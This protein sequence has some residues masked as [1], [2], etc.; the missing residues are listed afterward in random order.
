VKWRRLLRW[1]ASRLGLLCVALVL[2]LLVGELILRVAGTPTEQPQQQHRQAAD[3]RFLACDHD[4]LLGWIFPANAAGDFEDDR[5][6]II[7]HTNSWGLRG[8][9]I[10][11]DP[12][13]AHI[14]VLGDSYTF[15][16]G[17]EEAEGFPRRLEHRLRQQYPELSLTVVNT[18]I[19]GYGPYQQNRMLEYVCRRLRPDVV[20]ATFSLA[21]D[22]VDELRI[23]RFA[24][25]RLAQY[26][27]ELRDPDSRFARLI[28][29]S[30]LLFLLDQRTRYLQ[31][32]LTNAGGGALR[33]VDDSF[34]HLVSA[35]RELD[36]PLLMV[37]VPQRNQIRSKGLSARL[38]SLITR[39]L[40]AMPAK[41]AERHGIPLV[42]LTSELREVQRRTPAYLKNDAHWSPAGHEAAARAIADALPGS[43]LTRRGKDPE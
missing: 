6:P 31:T 34:A 20:I 1:L 26:T 29:G 25:D 33:R 39:R 40:R 3:S 15:G 32:F 27:P 7:I 18:G 30:R 38:T 21:N 12:A 28:C 43:W 4:S 19:P 16:W 5:S 42:D 22:P 14:V 17:V 35:C 36:T 10:D 8:P 11:L 13:N 41:I 23:A 9:E 24:P 37:V 2:A